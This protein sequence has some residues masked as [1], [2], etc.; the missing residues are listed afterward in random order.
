MTRD[1]AIMAASFTLRQGRS[2]VTSSSVFLTSWSSASFLSCTFLDL[3]LTWWVSQWCMEHRKVDQG[4]GC[5]EK[6]GDDGGNYVQLSCKEKRET[7][8]IQ[9]GPKVK[10]EF[11]YPPVLSARTVD[12]FLNLYNWGILWKESFPWWHQEFTIAMSVHPF[13]GPSLTLGS[14]ATIPTTTEQTGTEF[15]RDIDGA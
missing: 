14:I 5:Q 3:D 2:L 8:T 1:C 15:G 13:V 9:N 4:I 10:P 11:L 6:V 7:K 12:W